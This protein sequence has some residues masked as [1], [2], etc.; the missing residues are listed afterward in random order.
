M[1]R[2]APGS[3]IFWVRRSPSDRRSPSRDRNFETLGE[4]H[5]ILSDERKSSRIYA[6]TNAAHD[7]ARRK[8]RPRRRVLF[9]STRH[10][11]A[12]SAGLSR[13]ALHLGISGAATLA[14]VGLNHEVFRAPAMLNNKLAAECLRG[15]ASTGRQTVRSSGTS[16]RENLACRRK[17]SRIQNAVTTRMPPTNSFCTCLASS[18]GLTSPAPGLMT[19]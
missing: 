7:V 17:R 11:P 13:R 19:Y 18:P 1:T 8:S 4:C 5:G 9:G 12:A 15:I 14:S 6:S 10:A 3:W 16:S 2:S